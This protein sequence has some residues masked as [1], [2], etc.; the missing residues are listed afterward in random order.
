M[1]EAKTMKN[2][3]VIYYKHFDFPPDES[4]NVPCEICGNPAKDVHHIRRRGMG[5]S[6]KQ[7]DIKN[8][9]ALCR[10]HH[11]EFGDKKQYLEFLKMVHAEFME[12]PRPHFE[13]FGERTTKYYL[14]NK[15]GH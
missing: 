8:L 15:F 5:G 13:K 4:F 1:L 3:T 14:K 7:D 11:L 12:D 10:E 2:H 6:I 9:M